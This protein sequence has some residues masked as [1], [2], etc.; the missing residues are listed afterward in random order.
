MESPFGRRF[1]AETWDDLNEYHR[2]NPDGEYELILFIEKKYWYLKAKGWVKL[3]VDE[4]PVI[5][6]MKVV[7]KPFG[8]EFKE[9]L[10]FELLESSD[11]LNIFRPKEKKRKKSKRGKK[12]ENNL[13][14]QTK[15]ELNRIEITSEVKK[16]IDLVVSEDDNPVS[17]G[18][19]I[20]E[21]RLR[22]LGKRIS[23]KD[24]KSTRLNSS[25]GYI[26]H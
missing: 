6:G 14:E 10:E 18:E 12:S 23:D 11:E 13:E 2:K 5:K 25:H 20:D 1:Y 26:Y 3:D 7:E 9:V 17:I 19:K 21:E 15:Y 22:I 24:R 8:L 16:E 4:S